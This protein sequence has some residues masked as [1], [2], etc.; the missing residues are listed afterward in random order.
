MGNHIDGNLGIDGCGNPQHLRF[1][2]DV[3]AVAG[4][5]LDGGRTGTEHA[6]RPGG[7]CRDQLGFGRGPGRRHRGQDPASGSQDLLVA[8]PAEAAPEFLCPVSGEHDMGM[9]VDEAGDDG[10]PATV[11]LREGGGTRRHLGPPTDPRDAAALDGDGRVGDHAEVAP[12]SPTGSS[13][14]RRSR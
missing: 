4:L 1:G 9:G 6:A 7:R 12:P 11:E 10:A 5:H 8:L 14:A 3:E 13:P 2:G